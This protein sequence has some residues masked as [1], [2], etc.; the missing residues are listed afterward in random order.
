MN[1]V[2]DCMID[3]SNETSECQRC[4]DAAKDYAELGKIVDDLV[5]LTKRLVQELRKSNK[6]NRLCD[7]AMAYLKRRNWQRSI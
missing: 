5:Y 4:V 7:S 2:S 1:D 3:D 6:N